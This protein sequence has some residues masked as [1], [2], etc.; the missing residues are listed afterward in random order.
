MSGGGG[1]LSVA[2]GYAFRYAPVPGGSAPAESDSVAG[3]TEAEYCAECAAT[4]C[5]AASP[6]R[7]AGSTAEW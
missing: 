3:A 7:G 6:C 5:W 1:E 4:A 2:G